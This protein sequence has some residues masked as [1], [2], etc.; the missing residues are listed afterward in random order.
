MDMPTNLDLSDISEVTRVLLGNN[1]YTISD[2]IDGEDKF[3][4]A[5]KNKWAL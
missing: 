3:G 1:A 2:N 4:T 5:P